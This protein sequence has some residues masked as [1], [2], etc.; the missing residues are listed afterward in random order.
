MS[1]A[2]KDENR[3]VA[4]IGVSKV[5][6]KTPVRIAVNPDVDGAGTPGLVVEV[7]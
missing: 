4:V 6:L 7:A 5:D 1:N 3:V 2:K